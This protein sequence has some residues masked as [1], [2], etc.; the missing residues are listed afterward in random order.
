VPP[1]TN[2]AL[3]LE[4][5]PEQTCPVSDDRKESQEPEW[6]GAPAPFDGLMERGPD[7]KLRPYVGPTLEEALQAMEEDEKSA[8]GAH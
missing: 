3:D 8:A 4:P 5:T 6:T 2:R 7:G 1:I